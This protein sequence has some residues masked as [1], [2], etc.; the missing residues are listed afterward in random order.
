MRL[1]IEFHGCYGQV[2]RQVRVPA[3]CNELSIRSEPQE[4]T[5][6]EHFPEPAGFPEWK[7]K[8]TRFQ[9]PGAI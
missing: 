9:P 7:P 4:D 6:K 5:R 2:R 1:V 3:W 8:R